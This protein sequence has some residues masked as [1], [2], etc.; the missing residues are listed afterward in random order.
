MKV[1]LLTLLQE[2]M[3]QLRSYPEEYL[4]QQPEFIYSYLFFGFGFCLVW[5]FQTEVCVS[6]SNILH[7]CVYEYVHIKLHIFHLRDCCLF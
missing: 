5:P 6:A 4:V 7:L 3:L 2:F 1:M